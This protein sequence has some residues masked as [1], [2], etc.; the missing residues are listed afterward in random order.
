M[1]SAVQFQ[2]IYPTDSHGQI[3]GMGNMGDRPYLLFFDLTRC[4]NPA[5]LSLG[6]PTPQVCVHE[7]P[8]DQYSGYAAAYASSLGDSM[9]KRRMKPYCL[10]VPDSEWDRTSAMDLLKK[11]ICPS[12]WLPSN[13]VLG[14]C[15]PLVVSS[16]EEESNPNKT[17]F[18]E[19]QT[20]DGKPVSEGTISSA[21]TA[22]GA[23]LQLRGLG[24]RVFNDLS[25]TWWMI[26]V[27]MVAACIISF[28]WIILMRFFAGI[29]VWVSLGG[30]CLLFGGLFGWTLYK[31]IKIKDLP[32]AQGNIFQVNV[33]PDYG[34]DLLALA[35]T[36]LAF[37]IMLGI[38]FGIVVLVLIA[39]RQRIAIA[40]ELIEEGS[41]AVGHMFTTLFWPVF[42][43]VLHIV[44]KLIL[45]RILMHEIT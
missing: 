38:V 43:F 39:L 37:A 12:W 6:C 16:N 9:I 10:H 5:V 4:L 27:A 15:L 28:L 22:L 36:W 45:S 13:P 17:V 14:R 3:C 32:T 30:I 2:V 40:I 34:K 8:K 23:F 21:V 7:C 42:P 31:Y 1:K 26:G 11:E 29:M 18:G 24:E 41:K 44:G 25:D 33:T 20:M 35:E 19:G